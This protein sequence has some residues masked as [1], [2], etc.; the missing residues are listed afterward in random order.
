MA[1]RERERKSKSRRSLISA[2][3][4]RKGIDTPRDL[5]AVPAGIRRPRG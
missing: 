3:Y 4:F 1:E 5:Y 2:K